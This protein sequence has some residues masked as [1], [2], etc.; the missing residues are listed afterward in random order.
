MRAVIREREGRRFRYYMN[1]LVGT[2]LSGAARDRA[3]A[4]APQLRLLDFGKSLSAE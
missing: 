4:G 3:H 1:P 2:G